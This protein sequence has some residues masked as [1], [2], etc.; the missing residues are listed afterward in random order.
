M[1]EDKVAVAQEEELE[2]SCEAGELA[3]G[4]AAVS[5]GSVNAAGE[6]AQTEEQVLSSVEGQTAQAG[7]AALDS[8]PQLA[9]AASADAAQ[10]TQ[11]LQETLRRSGLELRRNE[12]GLSLVGDG[13]ELRADFADLLPR[14][15]PGRLSGELLVKAAKLKG[16]DEPCA[17]DATAG[18]GAD[19]F[20]LAAAGFTVV[21]FESDPVIAALL[22]DA[23]KRARAD[24][25]LAAIAGR[26]HLVEGDSIGG[27]AKLDVRPDLVLL[28]PMFPERRKSAAVKK[29]FQLIHR[30]ERPCSNE[31]ELFEAAVA[32]G[33]RKIVIK[34]PPKGPFLAGKKPSYSLKSKAVRY[35]CHVF[36]REL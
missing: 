4:Q 20:L 17:V 15:K 34:R 3:A 36:A 5:E 14:I 25:R 33:P 6:L 2:P 30:L 19:S 18:L 31:E 12:A 8:T 22:D 21:L 16:V 26:M 1:A 10:S 29:K 23:L 35:D 24:E 28:D 9:K 13:M 11:S 32:A 7:M 27:L